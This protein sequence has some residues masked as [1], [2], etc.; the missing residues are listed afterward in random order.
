MYIELVTFCQRVA[1]KCRGPRG[2]L[3]TSEAHFP[4]ERLVQRFDLTTNLARFHIRF[5][6]ISCPGKN[7]DELVD[8]AL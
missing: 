8:G 1:V 2:R 3:V 4:L 7:G 6:D 5:D